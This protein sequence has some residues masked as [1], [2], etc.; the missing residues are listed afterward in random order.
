MKRNV[1]VYLSALFL[2]SCNIQNKDVNVISVSQKDFNDAPKEQINLADFSGIN[3]YA[4]LLVDYIQSEKSC[5]ILEG[6]TSLFDAVEYKVNNGKLNISM[7]SGTY[8]DLWLKITA[9]SPDIKEISIAGSGDLYCESISLGHDL[10]LSSM[11][12]G[13]V[14]VE[15]INCDDMKFD[16]M[17]S[18]DLSVEKINAN[19][20]EIE[21]KGSGDVYIND[22]DIEDKTNVQM[23]G[24]GDVTLNGATKFIEVK[25]HGSGDLTGKLKYEKMDSDRNGSGDIKFDE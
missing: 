14:R 5:I 15:E 1:F 19:S 3:S 21:T 8:E 24:S 7:K 18:G 9:C 13:D 17:G 23:L 2:T 20:L 12:S 11:G 16:F 6:D 4:P 10:S 22:L 25:L